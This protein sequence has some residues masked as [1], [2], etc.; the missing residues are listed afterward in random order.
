MAQVYQD[1]IHEKMMMSPKKKRLKLSSEA[2]PK[3]LS[4]KRENEDNE[5]T[6]NKRLK[7]VLSKEEQIRA[8][9]RKN[10]IKACEQA[11][12]KAYF[13]IRKRI[14]L[15]DL[16]TCAK[17]SDEHHHKI[18]SIKEMASHEQEAFKI[19]LKTNMW[20]EA[21]NV[22]L[23]CSTSSKYLSANLLKD[24]AEILL[25]AHEDDFSEYSRADIISQCQLV[26]AQNLSFHP[27][28]INKKLRKC[29][30]DFL[31]SPMD[32]REN[33]FT[34]RK[35]FKCEEGLIKYCLNRLEHELSMESKDEALIN[36]DEH[37]PEDMKNSVKGLHWE[38]EKFE[39]Y[40]LLERNERIDRLMAFLESAVE[41]LQFDLA[42][43]HSRYTSHLSSHIMRSHKPLMAIIL[44]SNNILFTGA[45]NNKC[46]QILKIFTY[47]VHLKYPQNHID[48]ITTWL[49]ITVQTFYICETNANSDYPNIGKYCLSFAKEF[50]KIMSVLPHNS[51]IRIIKT[52]RPNFMQY[53]IGNLHINKLLQNEE[54]CILT[55][56]INF[57][58][59][60][61][62]RRLPILSSEIE[63]LKKPKRKTTRKLNYLS[64]I[65]KKY[66]QSTS[67]DQNS[68]PFCNESN[69]MYPKYNPD[70]SQDEINLNHVVDTFY[71][72]LE[73]YL[74]AYS[75]Q[76]VQDTINILNEQLLNQDIELRI[77][78][79]NLQRSYSV[80]EQFIK[81]Y[82]SIYQ[83]LKELVRILQEMKTSNDVPEILKIFGN[84]D[85]IGL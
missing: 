71:L 2:D 80:T 22:C 21:L 3:N 44:W 10:F 26:Y 20:Y 72:T 1:T 18:V 37:I 7:P 68:Q 69:N 12:N 4:N 49:N 38:K 29:Y 64:K 61:E 42:V 9:K 17:N 34:N 84:I 5:V 28:C 36:K 19:E 40:E 78:D 79:L 51:I 58:K 14:G 56:L 57:L 66:R 53:L 33:T 63:V 50:Y 16:P 15:V 85:L 35:L 39:L 11:S 32:L 48:I 70:I 8:L 52:I 25:N 83:L 45:V 55:N 46:R 23:L 81:K 47:F 62:W 6:S 31:T 41:L 59:E 30:L 65:C 60:Q 74:E 76:T 13:D 77:N 75:V 73:S 24:I 54:T 43:W 82:R 67:V 27:P